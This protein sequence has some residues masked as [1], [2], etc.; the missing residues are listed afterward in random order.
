VAAVTT[1]IAADFITTVNVSDI[2]DTIKQIDTYNYNGGA[3]V[4]RDVNLTFALWAI[5]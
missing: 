5:T 4:S 2:S 1:H 3:D